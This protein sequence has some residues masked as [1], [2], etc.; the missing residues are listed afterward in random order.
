VGGDPEAHDVACVASTG[1]ASTATALLEGAPLTDPD[2]LR[3]RRLRRNAASALVGL[4]P[5]AV[6]ALCGH[7]GDP[8]DEVRD[9]AALC[10]GF[11]DTAEARACEVQALAAGPAEARAAA[12][13]AL[14]PQIARGGIALEDGWGIA[15]GL[16]G[17]AEAS[18]R[19]SGLRLLPLFAADVAEPR[20]RPLVADSDP[21]VSVAAGK[22]LAAIESART[23]D[24]LE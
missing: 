20:A 5:A 6:D 12:A 17:D 19:V 24:A 13:A 16:L 22:A 11:S 3:A 4:G 21:A 7:L 9:L 23:A 15:T 18:A 2:P 8:R 10:L 1:T 14:G